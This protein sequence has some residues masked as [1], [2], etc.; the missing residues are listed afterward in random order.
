[1]RWVLALTVL[2]SLG[3]AQ[4]V[5]IV[6]KVAYTDDQDAI[7]LVVIENQGNVPVEYLKVVANVYDGKGKFL[8]S[9]YTYSATDIL[10]PR[11]R[12]FAEIRIDGAGTFAKYD[13]DIQFRAG[14]ARRITPQII[15]HRGYEEDGAFYVVGQVKN[16]SS[17][18]IEYVKVI[19]IA[20]DDTGNIA[21][22]DYT[23]TTLDKLKSSQISPFEIR[24]EP[25]RK[26]VKYEVFVQAR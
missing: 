19:A 3:F 5:S 17:T 16:T 25:I 10:M 23:Y 21:G 13:V 2:L 24:I 20:Y 11:E 12:T 22:A 7:I 15:S 8:D 9:D 14:Q 18:S 26:A 4:S 1:M 6:K